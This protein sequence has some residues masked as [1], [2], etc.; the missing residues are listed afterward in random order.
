MKAFADLYAQL[1]A[2]KRFTPAINRGYAALHAAFA[3][4]TGR[5]LGMTA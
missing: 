2:T 1:D 4:T 3:A 5:R